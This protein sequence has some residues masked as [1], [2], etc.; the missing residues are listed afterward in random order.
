MIHAAVV[1]E[2][3]DHAEILARVGARED[4]AALL[5]LGM[6]R[7]HADGRPVTGMSY[8]SYE[9]MAAP[10]LREI[11]TEAAQRIGSDRVAVV[12][13]VGD[14]DIGEVS[15]AIAVSSPHRAEAYDASRYVI[16][17]I[18]KRLPVWKKE[19]Y[20]DGAQEWVAGTVPP[21]AGAASLSPEDAE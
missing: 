21:G 6:V 7:D 3:I 11:A 19:H 16:E 18:K 12:H 1:H 20:A 17:E 14:L 2:V 9:E 8:E 15:V 10:V 13:R 5:F 4:G